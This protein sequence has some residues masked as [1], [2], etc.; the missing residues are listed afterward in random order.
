MHRKIDI[1]KCVKLQLA[2]KRKTDFHFR[3]ETRQRI[4]K[5]KSNMRRNFKRRHIPQPSEKPFLA[6]AMDEAIPWFFLAI[7]FLRMSV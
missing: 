2:E 6:F 5:A 7:Y 3:M 4:S 1:T